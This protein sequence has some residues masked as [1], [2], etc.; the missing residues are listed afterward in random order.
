VIDGREHVACALC[1][2]DDAAAW[3][4]AG[5]V[6]FPTG[7]TFSAVRCRRCGLRYLDPRPTVEAIGRY[8]PGAY[9]THHEVPE[10][11]L[12]ATYA[13]AL[14]AVARHGQR[15]PILDVGCGD[16]A[17]LAL[18]RRRGWT[19]AEGIEADPAA[20]A[21][22]VENRGLSVA[23]GHFPGTEPP[24]PRYA[25]VTMLEVIEHLHRPREALA[26]VRELLEPGGRLVL[27]TPSV[28]GL[29]FRLLGGRSVSLQLP[30]HLYFFTPETL[31][32]LLAE[33]GLRTVACHTTASTAG[34][35]RSLWL[36]ARS[37][38]RGEAAG[39]GTGDGAPAG[40]VYHEDSWRRRAHERLEASLSPL[41]GLLAR[42]GLGPG[43]V[44]VAERPRGAR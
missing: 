10:E 27:T 4:A 26:A 32:R 3:L 15:G 22:A 14:R 41:G 16:G 25:T 28:D 13:D 38:R 31:D 9:Y 11:R 37:A 39:D 23:L 12:L 18:L 2:A 42:R 29:E 8:Y 40:D 21:V 44:V 30:R 34:L 17:F 24:R 35:T 20:R 6:E 1:G 36:L 43:M 33:E 7:E 19:E 5:D